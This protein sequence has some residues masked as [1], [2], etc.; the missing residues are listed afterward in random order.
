MFKDLHRILEQ[1]KPDTSLL[2]VC[3]AFSAILH[4]HLFCSKM[5]L[6]VWLKLLSLY[7]ISSSQGLL[8][9]II[10]CKSR[11]CYVECKSW[12]LVL[13]TLKG[14]PLS[15]FLLC[16]GTRKEK[17]DWS[18]VQCWKTSG[19]INGLTM[20]SHLVLKKQSSLGISEFAKLN[21]FRLKGVPS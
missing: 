6:V 14:S 20:I 13:D 5:V 21:K 15:I 10:C 11:Q 7:Y 2:L 12:W 1:H 16:D 19:C 8:A 18:S 9:D 3:Y 17:L 4:C